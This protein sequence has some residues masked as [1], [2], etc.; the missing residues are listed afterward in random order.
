MGQD[1][2][3]VSHLFAIPR[4]DAD[5]VAVGADGQIDWRTFAHDVAGLTAR[6]AKSGGRRW[7]LADADG[8]ALAVGVLATL[9]AEC[10]PMLPANLEHGHLADLTATADGVISSTPPLPVAA[11]C[12]LTFDTAISGDNSALHALDPEKAEIIL[13]TS[14]TTGAPIVVHKPLRCLEAEIASV[15]KIFAPEP[16]RLTL[17][18]VPPYHIYGLIFRIL[19]PL[20]TGR[21]F[22][23]HMI[24]YPEEL[25]A[26]FEK[27]S[28]GMLISS[29]AFLRRAL[30]ALD[31]EHLKK[32][33]GPVL[34]SGGPLPPT[35]AAAYNA[36]LTEPVSEVYGSTET[37]GIAFRSVTNAEAPELWR[38][39]PTVEVKIDEEEDVLA[40][41]SPMLPGRDW[42]LSSDRVILHADGCF[43]LKGRAD[44]VVKIE[45]RRVSLTEIEQRLDACPTVEAA[46]VIALPGEDT[47]RQILAAVI[48]PSAAGWDVLANS[49][50]R[51]LRMRLLDVLKPYLVAIVLPR[52]WRFVTRIPEDDR[53]KTSNA[54]LVALFDENQNRRVD[55][56][57]V[58]REVEQDGLVLHLHL[59]NDLFYFD[60]HFEE[61]P[62]LAGVVQIDWAVKFAMEHFEILEKFRR[63]EALKFFKVLMAGDDVT[64]DLR[65]D[66]EIRRLKFQYQNSGTKHSSGRIVFDA[67][68]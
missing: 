31:L 36:V 56:V 53:G 21:P 10:L 8:Y 65:Y 52:K 40:I 7:L 18:T 16:G 61:A 60:G 29:P 57:I 3:P 63:I 2:T 54:S 27:N 62:I 12:L 48:E 15:A 66:P 49:G 58:K 23:A 5:I 50:R 45:E 13:H 41:R 44:R 35:V 37:G 30:P 47:K 38:P 20:S 34:S 43:E 4:R 26:A 11:N 51:E 14:G 46:R 25:I 28:G 68:P 64:L 9:Q 59:P 42:A 6:I 22:S 67:T 55:P 1:V 33:L 24:S 39:L 17:A 32:F 19:W